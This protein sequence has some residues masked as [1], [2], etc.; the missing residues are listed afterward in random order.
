[1]CGFIADTKKAHIIGAFCTNKKHILSVLF[2][3]NFDRQL[4]HLRSA[5]CGAAFSFGTKIPR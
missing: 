5:N 1:M 3:P 4:P 2:A